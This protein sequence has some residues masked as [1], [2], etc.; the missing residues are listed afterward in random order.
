LLCDDP[1]PVPVTVMVLP[2]DPELGDIPVI[3]RAS[4]TVNCALLLATPSTVTVTEPFVAVAGTCTLILLSLQELA[5]ATTLLNMT[6]L[7]PWLVPK[8]L[9]VSTVKAPSWDPGGLR[10]TIVGLMT[11]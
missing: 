7:V 10:A 4:S 8:P 9:P 2:I 1:K 3:V 11:V 5:N 6:W